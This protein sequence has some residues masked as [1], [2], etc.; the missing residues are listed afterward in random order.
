MGTWSMWL[1]EWYLPFNCDLQ[2]TVRATQVHLGHITFAIGH[3]PEGFSG[4]LKVS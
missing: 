3:F 1:V 2:A 4:S